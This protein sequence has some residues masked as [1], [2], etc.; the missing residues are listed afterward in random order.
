MKSY[1]G[2][3]AALSCWYAFFRGYRQHQIN[4]VNREHTNSTVHDVSTVA[5]RLHPI[6]G[7]T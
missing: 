1:E 5:L 4:V 7:S 2:R 3:P 6:S